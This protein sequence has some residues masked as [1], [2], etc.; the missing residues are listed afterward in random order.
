MGSDQN[1]LTIT[2]SGHLFVFRAKASLLRFDFDLGDWKLIAKKGE[3][4]L[5]ISSL[6]EDYETCVSFLLDDEE[7]ENPRYCCDNTLFSAVST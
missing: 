4:R 6:E 7:A 5:S 2:S 3:A 1:F